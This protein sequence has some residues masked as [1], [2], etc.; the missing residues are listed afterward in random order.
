MAAEEAMQLLKLDR[1]P[2][3]FELLRAVQSAV[4][5][6]ENNHDLDPEDLVIKEAQ[7]SDATR[8]RRLLPRARGRAEVIRKRSCHILVVVSD[9]EAVAARQSQPRR[10]TARAGR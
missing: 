5:N 8:M 10:G 2:S 4:S 7:A 6:A 9:D 3:A 1:S